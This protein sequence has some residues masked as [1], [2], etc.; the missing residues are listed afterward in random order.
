MKISNSKYAP[1]SDALLRQLL[2]PYGVALTA[3]Q[4]HQIQRYISLLVQWNQKVNLTSITEF[5]QIIELHFGESIFAAHVAPI[6][7]GRLADAGSGAGFPGLALKIACP[8]LRVVLIEANSKKAAFLAEVKRRLELEHVEI[9][10]SRYEE[11]SVPA[12]FADYVSARAVGGFPGLLRWARGVLAPRG[13]LL[14]WLGADDSRR[15]SRT[16]GWIWREPVAIPNSS[17]RVLLVGEPG[18][19]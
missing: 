4:V 2:A 6:E 16:S 17:N 15:I 9:L 12:G 11:L 19:V 10:R 14:L 8:E 1:V 7:R 18:L 5:R 3:G 13:K